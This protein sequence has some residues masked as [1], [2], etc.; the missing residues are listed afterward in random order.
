MAVGPECGVSER[1]ETN[2]A[3]I[4][5]S[6][7]VDAIAE[8][9]I[10]GVQTA[11]EEGCYE[12]PTSYDETWEFR[13]FDLLKRSADQADPRLQWQVLR[14]MFSLCHFVWE[15]GAKVSG[16][17]CSRDVE[18]AALTTLEHE[19][20]P[21]IRQQALEI[22]VTGFATEESR[23]RLEGIVQGQSVGEDPC[24]K[25]TPLLMNDLRGQT[26]DALLLE[27]RE[28]AAERERQLASSALCLLE[29]E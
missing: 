13:A 25:T 23:S 8:V 6:E 22:L 21:L 15:N 9:A 28:G 10:E 20:E 2:T 7:A 1:E 14:A 24:R 3:C 17:G 26:F 27:Y 11:F 12:E 5:W 18:E 16:S 4:A 19:S 29:G